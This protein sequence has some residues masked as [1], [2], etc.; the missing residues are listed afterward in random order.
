MSA[1]VFSCANIAE[2]GFSNDQLAF[3][4]DKFAFGNSVCHWNTEAMAAE[5]GPL[6]SYID[7]PL[8]IIND[9]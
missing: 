8:K 9:L 3:E 1:K 5:N 7:I 4:H 6:H 2:K